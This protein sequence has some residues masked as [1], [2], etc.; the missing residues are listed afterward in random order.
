MAELNSLVN[1]REVEIVLTFRHLSDVSILF[2]FVKIINL[3]Y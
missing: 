2:C 1:E 3:F